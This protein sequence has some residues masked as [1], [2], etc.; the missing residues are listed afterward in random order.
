MVLSRIRFAASEI[1]FG[2]EPGVAQLFEA[3]EFQVRKPR[4]LLGLA[5]PALGLLDCRERGL[6]FAR[7]RLL[8]GSL[9]L[10]ERLN[11]RG[12]HAQPGTLLLQ[13]QALGIAIQLDQQIPGRNLCAENQTGLD[14]A[15]RIR[16]LDEM[17][18]A[19]DFE[20][21][22]VGSLIARHPA[23]KQPGGP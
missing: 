2:D 4:R 3:I 17:D 7:A 22:A 20:P 11:L 15:S 13:L 9:L 19:I 6:L 5:D 21:R 16:R 18:G 10:S 23:E 8:D 14:D 12:E 1:P